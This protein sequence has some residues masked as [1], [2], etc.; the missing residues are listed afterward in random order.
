MIVGIDQTY[1]HAHEA[2]VGIV[3][4]AVNQPGDEEAK[5]ED[6]VS[7]GGAELCGK[8]ALQPLSPGE[9]CWWMRRG[10]YESSPELLVLVAI[11]FP[12]GTVG[13]LVAVCGR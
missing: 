10:R 3:R 13:R 7:V 12:G 9:V 2:L 4:A 1:L 11:L 6:E 5:N 8:P